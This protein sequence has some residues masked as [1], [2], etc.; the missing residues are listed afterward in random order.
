VAARVV[1]QRPPRAGDNEGRYVT[2]VVA[3]ETTG[4]FKIEGLPA[5]EFELVAA[6]ISGDERLDPAVLPV[7]VD[8]RY[9]SVRNLE[10]SWIPAPKPPS[11]TDPAVDAWL[12]LR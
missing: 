6:S 1:A 5:G 8:T 4:A 3:D 2:D 11:P 12:G 7:E 9:G 10:L